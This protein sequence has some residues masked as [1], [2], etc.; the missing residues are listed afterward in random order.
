MTRRG[1]LVATAILVAAGMGLGAWMG[2]PEKKI[3][4]VGQALDRLFVSTS[5]RALESK[6][7]FSPV[8]ARENRETYYP[9]TEDLAP[10][11]MRVTACGTGMPSARP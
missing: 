1:S 7:T 2:A 3:E 4:A 11:E 10:D 8:K 9:G 5:A 6:Q